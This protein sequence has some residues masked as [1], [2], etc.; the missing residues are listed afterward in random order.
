LCNDKHSICGFF[1]AGGKKDTGR[2]NGHQ[3]IKDYG[4][5][6]FVHQISF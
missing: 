1:L 3:E 6:N 2:A 4:R 5:S